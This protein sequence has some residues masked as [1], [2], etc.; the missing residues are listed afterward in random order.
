MPEPWHVQRDRI[1]SLFAPWIAWGTNLTS[2]ISIV[3]SK[4]HN[5]TREP[6][7]CDWHRNVMI[8]AQ[9]QMNTVSTSSRHKFSVFSFT[10]FH[11][12]IWSLDLLEIDGHTVSILTCN[13]VSKAIILIEM[14]QCMRFPTMWY[15]R[16]AKPQTSLR[17]R[18]VWSEP[19]L[20]AWIFYEC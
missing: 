10:P 2:T 1:T 4:S 19:L 15:V 12:N 6:S 17:I 3:K 14:S 11:K 8:W 20:V 16:P 18:A 13:G 5:D 7:V 9:K